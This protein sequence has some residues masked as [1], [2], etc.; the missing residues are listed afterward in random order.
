VDPNLVVLQPLSQDW[1]WNLSQDMPYKR[2]KTYILEYLELD[3]RLKDVQLVYY[4]DVD[5]V[6]GRSLQPW[7]D[8]VEQTYLS[9]NN[10]PSQMIFFNG[11]SPRR[12]LQ[13]GQFLVE[14]KSSQ[15]CLERWRHFIDANPEDPK[16]QSALTLILQEQN[17]S[18]SVCHLT[19]MPQSPY[20]QFLDKQLM[21]RLV[22]S[23]EYSTLMHIKNTEHADWIPNRI[24]QRFFQQ[25]LL[26]SSEEQ[27][28]VGKAQIHP[29]K[30]R[31]TIATSSSPQ[32]Q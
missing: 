2:F 3:H 26:L 32:Q 1:R 18:G 21:M 31:S 28:V 7:F 25:L 4:L 17:I 16:D 11:N 27:Q 30:T 13:G 12:P 23:Q 15:P 9:Q 29:S 19:I 14:R 5:V 22:K 20:L 6:V 8:H 24:Q 10:N